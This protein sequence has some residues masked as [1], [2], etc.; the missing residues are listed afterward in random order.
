MGMLNAQFFLHIESPLPKHCSFS[1][2]CEQKYI[3]SRVDQ[4]M[5]QHIFFYQ[6]WRVNIFR[7]VG[8][9]ETLRTSCM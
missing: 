2:V 1:S 7:F 9:E 3:M 5:G 8:E 4:S 6:G